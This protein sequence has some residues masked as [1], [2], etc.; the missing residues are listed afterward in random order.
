MA[1][2]F[3]NL[4]RQSETRFISGL[5]E[6][7]RESA[8]RIKS[9]M[10]TFDDLQRLAGPAVQT[11]LRSVEKDK[12]PIALKGAS[13]KIKDLFFKNTVERAA[14]MLRDD[15]ALRLGPVRL[16]DVDEAQSS[17]V[18]V[19]KELAMQGQIE[20]N[21]TADEEVFFIDHARPAFH[22][23]RR[24]RLPVRR[25]FRSADAP[26]PWA[27]TRGDRSLIHVRRIA[28]GA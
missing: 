22:C 7:N 1:E 16:R 5:E 8:E 2:I 21:S 15:I 13:D 24:R 17:I 23:P 20:I 9:L 19:A 18:G 14:K 4:D 3:N 10:F 25:G 12:L 11:L 6:R 28:G 27:G 26:R